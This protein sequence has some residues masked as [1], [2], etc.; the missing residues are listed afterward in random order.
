MV[1]N[2]YFESYGCPSNRSD[3]EIMLSCLRDAGFKLTSD[4][5][6]ADVVLINT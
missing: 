2:I 1:R 6:S 5:G 4:I 3:L